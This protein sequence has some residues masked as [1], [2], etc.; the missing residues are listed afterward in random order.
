MKFYWC[1]HTRAV[2]I[3]WLLEELGRPYERITIDIRDEEARANPD[4][5]A[6]SPMGKVPAL[7]DGSVKLWDSGAICIYLADAYPE[8]GLGVAIGDPQRGAFLQWAMFTNAVIEPA[9]GEKFAGTDVNT[10][11]H[12]YGSFDLMIS[13]LIDGL[14]PGPW[15]LGERFTAAD[16]LLGTSVYFL[17]TFGILSERH[18]IIEAYAD[19]CQS[20][21]AFQRAQAMQGER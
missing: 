19:R 20:R 3:A 14:T 2:R 21:P 4:F 12:G 1:P 17:S 11:Q 16:V 8:A 13:T 15:V 7:V 5:R 10:S 6:V 9:M 18:P